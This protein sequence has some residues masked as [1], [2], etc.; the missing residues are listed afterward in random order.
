MPYYM[1]QGSYTSDAWTA[2][3]KNPVDRT[4]AFREL[5]EK[6]GGRVIAF[7]Y[8]FGEYD[9]VGITELPDHVSAAAG[10]L[11]AVAA[12]HLKNLKTTVLLTG[13]DT[14]AA[15]RKAGGIGYKGP[16]GS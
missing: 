12:G 3:V 8:C 10:S 9:V 7:Y 11:A 6:V 1:I 14:L 4:K 13:D 16:S 2:M 5:I 15:L